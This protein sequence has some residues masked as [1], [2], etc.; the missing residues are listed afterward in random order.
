MF[1][2]RETG[3]EGRRGWREKGRMLFGR[4]EERR[5]DRG[6]ESPIPSGLQFSIHPNVGDL[7]ENKDFTSLLTFLP[8]E[9]KHFITM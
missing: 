3:G 6:E 5:K 2:T 4:M 9:K 8:L 1:C 7:G